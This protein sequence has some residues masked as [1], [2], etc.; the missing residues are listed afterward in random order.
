ML[1]IDPHPLLDCCAFVT[2]FP[3]PLGELPSPLRLLAGLAL[4]Y[5]DAPIHSDDSIRAAVRDLLRHGGLFKPTGRSK[6]ASEYLLKAA[7]EGMDSINLAVD[8]CNVASLH[9]GL[10]ISVV[11]LDLVTPPLR[12]AVAPAG[13]SYVFNKSGQEIAIGG[14][15]SLWDAE[16]PCAGPVKDSQRSKTHAG[17]LR[18]L[19]IVWGTIGAPG[20]AWQTTAWYRELLHTAGATTEAAP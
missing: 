19:S 13:T 3:R 11:D 2:T 9:S 4:D 6:P 5:A 17:T 8:A 7:S 15:L 16:G 20:R 14:L 18:T 12:V 1:T 10:P